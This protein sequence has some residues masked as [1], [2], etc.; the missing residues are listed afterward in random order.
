MIKSTF[1]CFAGYPAPQLHLL[2]GHLGS[3]AQEHHKTEVLEMAH[4]LFTP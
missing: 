2:K 4:S 3:M 1:S